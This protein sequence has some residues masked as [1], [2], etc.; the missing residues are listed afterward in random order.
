MVEREKKRARTVQK[1]SAK[2]ALLKATLENS[3]AS[4]EEKRE[5]MLKLQNLP[6][7]ASPVR[8]RNRCAVTGRPR[9]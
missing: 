6:R 2:R 7:N 9:G 4:T 1:Y 3:Q 5:A 8:R